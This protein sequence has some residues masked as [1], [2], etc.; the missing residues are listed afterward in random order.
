MKEPAQAASLHVCV[1]TPIG[2]GAIA[3]IGISRTVRTKRLNNTFSPQSDRSRV[4]Q[5]E[6]VMAFGAA[7]RMGR[8]ANPW[9]FVQRNRTNEIG[10]QR[11]R[12]VDA[13]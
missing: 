2:R 13:I 8:S 1:L 12:A 4:S 9:S 10:V 3:T 5:D 11:T 6:F 7:V